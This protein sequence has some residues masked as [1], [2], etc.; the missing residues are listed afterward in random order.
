VCRR[1]ARLLGGEV[2]IESEP[3]KGST[4]R[5][6]FPYDWAGAEPSPGYRIV[7]SAGAREGWAEKGEAAK[8]Q[9]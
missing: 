8:P 5:V 3:G 2:T 6:R 7:R 9:G 4:F 1:L